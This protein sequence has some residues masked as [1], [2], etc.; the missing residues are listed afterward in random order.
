MS[1][2][3]LDIIFIS[4]ITLFI[5]RCYVK[6]FASEFLS[7]AAI[8]LATL[9]AIFF[10]KN[11]GNFVRARFWPE[12]KTIPEV[13]AFAGLFLIVFIIVKMI[14]MMVK[15]IIEKIEVSSGDRAFGIVFGLLE[16]IAIVSLV[17]FL[18]KA[19]PLFD[20]SSLLSESFFARIMLPLI[21]GREN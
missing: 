17:L 19:Q 1:F 2:N 7:M 13:A 14:E 20:S 21:T 18:L 15:G 12:L 9:A 3:I 16:G 11:G 10:Y 6:G 8:V 5:V 4:V